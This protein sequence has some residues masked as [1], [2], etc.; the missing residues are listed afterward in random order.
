MNLARLLTD[1]SQAN[2]ERVAILRREID[3]PD[4][5]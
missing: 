5:Q 4:G 3:L 2:G 1:S